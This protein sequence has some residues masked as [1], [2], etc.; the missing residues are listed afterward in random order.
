[1]NLESLEKK[2][3]KTKISLRLF[4]KQTVPGNE[5]CLRLS[6]ESVFIYLGL[7]KKTYPHV[8]TTHIIEHNRGIFSRKGIENKI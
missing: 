7:V 8:Y 2:E 5:K 3:R 4:D 6:V 1:M